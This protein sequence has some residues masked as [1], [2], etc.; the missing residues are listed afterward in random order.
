MSPAETA[1]PKVF[2]GERSCLGSLLDDF[3]VLRDV[4]PFEFRLAADAQTDHRV[5]HFQD[6]EGHDTAIN[7]RAGDIVELDQ[8]LPRVSVQKPAMRE[9]VDGVRSEDA[10]EHRTERAADA[11][12]APG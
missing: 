8:H 9:R 11:V 3:A 4:E 12:H 7:E 6:D 1:G 5:D 10:R 2:E